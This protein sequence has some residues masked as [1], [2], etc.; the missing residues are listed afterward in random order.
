MTPT[1]TLLCNLTDNSLP[2][3]QWLTTPSLLHARSH[4]TLAITHNT[5]AFT[6]QRTDWLNVTTALTPYFLF[7][8]LQYPVFY[9]PEDGLA[10]CTLS[11]NSPPRLYYQSSHVRRRTAKCAECK[12]RHHMTPKLSVT[13]QQNVHK[14]IKLEK[15]YGENV[16]I[17]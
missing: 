17:A 16:H 9:S 11:I 10:R 13:R 7:S 6:H 2:S 5:F 3:D 8:S 4:E 15:M 14:S 12:C 1:S